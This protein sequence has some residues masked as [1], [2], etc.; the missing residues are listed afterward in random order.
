MLDG[1]LFFLVKDESGLLQPTAKPSL[2]KE[3]Y[4]MITTLGYQIKDLY[5][6][7]R[8]NLE[9]RGYK[10]APGAK[11]RLV[12]ITDLDDPEAL[13]I[14]VLVE[15]RPVIAVEPLPVAEIVAPALPEVR[16]VRKT[17]GVSSIGK[18]PE[19]LDR[20]REYRQRSQEKK[21]RQAEEMAA[22]DLLDVSPPYQ[23]FHKPIE[24]EVVAPLPDPFTLPQLLNGIAGGGARITKPKKV[25]GCQDCGETDPKRGFYPKFED[26]DEQIIT[27]CWPCYERRCDA[28]LASERAEKAQIERKAI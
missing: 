17:R 23:E 12:D 24:V 1:W 6:Y 7:V 4:Q 28:E 27:I 19:Q 25:R 5:A 20:E 2:I 14:E 13:A 15:D 18:S 8:E 11:P 9:A 21:R 3:L 16:N 10:L 22:I 26:E